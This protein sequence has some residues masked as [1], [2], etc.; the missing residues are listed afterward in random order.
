MRTLS[1]RIAMKHL[2]LIA[3]LLAPCSMLSAAD[4]PQLIP[5]QGT[6]VN[7]VGTAYP[8]GQYAITFAIYNEAVGG[9][10]VWTERHEKV[11]VINGMVNVFL[12][13]INSFLKTNWGDNV[14]FG[15]TKYLG[16]TV[17]A[18][19]NPATAD[20]EMAPRQLLLTA[21]Y[22]PTTDKLQDYG[23]DVLFGNQSPNTSPIQAT[24]IPQLTL[25]KLS[26]IPGSKL[27][28]NITSDALA[29][30]GQSTVSSGGIVMSENANNTALLNAGYI[31]IGP[32]QMGEAWQNT[33]L[34]N[35]PSGRHDMASTWSGTE[36]LVWG[37]ADQSWNFFS[38]GARYNPLSNTWTSISSSGAPASRSFVFTK[39][40]WTG[41]EFFIWSSHSAQGGS[42]AFAIRSDGALYN[43]VTDQWRT[44]ATSGAPTPRTYYSCE[45]MPE[46]GKMFVWGGATDYLATAPVN[47][48]GLY[49]PAQ[50]VWTAMAASGAPSA[51]AFPVTAWTGSEILLWGGY[52]AS[53][54]GGD[55]HLTDGARYNPATN[56]WSPLPISGSPSQRNQVCSLWTGTEWFIWGGARNGGS[57]FYNTLN[58]GALFNPTTNTW[59]PISTIGAP[60]PR[61]YGSCAWNGKE[62]LIWGGYSRIGDHSSTGVY[63]SDGWR[64][65]PAKDQWSQMSLAG[66]PAVAGCAGA[67]AGDRL[68]IFGGRTVS[69]NPALSSAYIPPRTLYLYQKQ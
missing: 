26:Q 40:P 52:Y 35:A 53:V 2:A 42:G 57:P 4:S 55:N 33:S 46:V 7:S 41:S 16:I 1:L 65:D 64:Y 61:H 58:D 44:V 32:G 31:R 37:G 27:A 6:L 15:T 21:F 69:D 36:L 18:D 22:A 20:K 24:K 5:F 45:W 62:V 9:T 30:A 67:W 39:T 17:D 60:P 48:G 66:L 47:T 51:R 63:L 50:N 38:N 10:P 59:R 12:G 8:N 28:A 25:D 56:T 34:L 54:G 3:L 29:A 19:G 68:L 11:G 14:N 43:P 13:S 23:W 49:N